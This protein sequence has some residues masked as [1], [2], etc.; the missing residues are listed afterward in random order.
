MA[1]GGQPLAEAMTRI[2]GEVD[3]AFDL[4]MS[5]EAYAGLASWLEAAPPAARHVI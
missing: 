4:L 2:A 5:A 3:D 1:A